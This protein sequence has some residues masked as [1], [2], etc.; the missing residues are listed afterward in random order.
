MIVIAP[1]CWPSSR[2]S[3]GRPSA[4]KISVRIPPASRA[5]QDCRIDPVAA[6]STSNDSGRDAT[7]FAQ[8]RA[9]RSKK[10]TVIFRQIDSIRANPVV[11]HAPFRKRVWC[12]RPL[13]SGAGG[14]RSGLIETS[15]ARE[16]SRQFRLGSVTPQGNR[17]KDRVMHLEMTVSVG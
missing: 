15:G 14:T 4:R 9:N 1:N 11:P 6:S 16:G 3:I 12:G 8:N 7:E 17:S 13:L 2:S 10:T 5:R